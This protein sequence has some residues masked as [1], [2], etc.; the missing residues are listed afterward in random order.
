[1]SCVNLQ[2]LSNFTPYLISPL[3]NFATKIEH[4]T[5]IT[6]FD[7]PF[8]EQIDVTEVDL[9]GMIFCQV[10]NKMSFSLFSR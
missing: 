8:R 4:G 6:S 7:P 1:L 3:L 9:K 5:K 10:R 2:S